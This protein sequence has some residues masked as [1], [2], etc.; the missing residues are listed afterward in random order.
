MFQRIKNNQIQPSIVTLCE[1]FEVLSDS[2]LR[3]MYDDY[4]EEGLKKGIQSGN[5]SIDPWTYHGNAMTTYS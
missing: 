5:S 2:F 3:A 1:A 4:G